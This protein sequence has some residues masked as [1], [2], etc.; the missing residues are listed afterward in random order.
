MRLPSTQGCKP[1]RDHRNQRG[2]QQ[3]RVLVIRMNHHHDVRTGFQREPVA[4]FLIPAVASVFLVDVDLHAFQIARHR[5]GVIPAAII[6]END[7]IHDLLIAHLVVRLAQRFR[8]VIG[9]HHDD[10][11]FS[12]IHVGTNCREPAPESNPT[13]KNSSAA[14]GCSRPAGSRVLRLHSKT[15]TRTCSCLCQVARQ[16]SW[17]PTDAPIRLKPSNH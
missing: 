7:V 9:R 1:L 2:Q 4:S 16:Q 11:F 13:S 6:H 8:R 15:T 10:H 14:N 12:A 3:R 5:H 17:T